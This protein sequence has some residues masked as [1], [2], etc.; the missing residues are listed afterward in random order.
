MKPILLVLSVFLFSISCATIPITPAEQQTESIIKS[1]ILSDSHVV[2]ISEKIQIRKALVTDDKVMKQDQKEI[3]N[4]NKDLAEQKKWASRG[5][6]AFI[7][8]IFIL[9]LFVLKVIF[10]VLRFFEVI[11]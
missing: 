10:T 9:S 3:V 11:P 4:L 8:G 6:L 2:S 1:D 5:K 7:A